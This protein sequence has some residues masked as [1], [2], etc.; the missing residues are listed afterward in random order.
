[1]SDFVD[2]MATQGKSMEKNTG[3]SLIKN[4]PQT[5]FFR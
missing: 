1:M 5:Y 3:R 4:K 2:S